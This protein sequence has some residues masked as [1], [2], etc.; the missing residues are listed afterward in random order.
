MPFKTGYLKDGALIF[1][2]HITLVGTDSIN[3][4]NTDQTEIKKKVSL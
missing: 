1:E 4:G 2:D 3:L